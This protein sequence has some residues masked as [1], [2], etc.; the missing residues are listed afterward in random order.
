MKN[1]IKIFEPAEGEIDY[2]YISTF[3]KTAEEN[4]LQVGLL[5]HLHASPYWAT[6]K[7]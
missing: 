7:Y 2:D 3:L 5:F 6:K 1:Y 4:E